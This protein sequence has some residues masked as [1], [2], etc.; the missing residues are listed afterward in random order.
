MFLYA[1]NA[2]KCHASSKSVCTKCTHCSTQS[3]DISTLCSV[4]WI[5][6]HFQHKPT[7]HRAI[8]SPGTLSGEC[9]CHDGLVS[10]R[11]HDRRHSEYT[12]RFT[13]K[14]NKYKFKVKAFAFITRMRIMCLLGCVLVETVESLGNETNKNTQK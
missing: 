1:K 3:S 11:T 8:A 6:F 7:F 10:T 9:V 5:Q 14:T 2:P 12:K 13:I 4:D